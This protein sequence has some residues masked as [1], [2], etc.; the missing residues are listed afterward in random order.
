MAEG[1]PAWTTI[2]Q[3]NAPELDPAALERAARTLRE[4]N[5]EFGWTLAAGLLPYNPGG[6][7]PFVHSIPVGLHYSGDVEPLVATLKLRKVTPFNFLV[8][9]PQPALASA[10]G[11]V[12]AEKGLVPTVQQILDL[13]AL[14]GRNVEQAEH[15]FSQWAAG[16]PVHHD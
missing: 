1:R 4:R 3:F 7:A 12:F 13:N 5:F 9:R 16:L 6:P 14:G 11:G 15:L 10:R 8:L 2:T